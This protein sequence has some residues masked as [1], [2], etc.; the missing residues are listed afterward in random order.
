MNE[1]LTALAT[2]LIEELEAGYDLVKGEIPVFLEEVLQ[3]YSV[4][5]GVCTGL[6]GLVCVS[7]WLYLVWCLRNADNIPYDKEE[8][9][10]AV[11]VVAGFVMIATFIVSVVHLIPSLLKVTFAPRLFL[12][13]WVGNFVL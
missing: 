13:E 4:Y 6:A 2:R 10:G 1:K 8:F 9:Y 11:G 3:Y 7:C 5:Y 12:I